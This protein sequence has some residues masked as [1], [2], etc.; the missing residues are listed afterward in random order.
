MIW[1][2]WFIQEHMLGLKTISDEL[3]NKFN[4]YL[5][6]GWVGIWTTD[7]VRHILSLLHYLEN[8]SKWR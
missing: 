3:E 8:E 1:K 2:I 5:K 7:I 6:Y 4:I